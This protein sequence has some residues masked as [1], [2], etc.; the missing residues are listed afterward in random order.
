[1]PGSQRRG[2]VLREDFGGALLAA[3]KRGARRRAAARYSSRAAGRADSVIRDAGRSGAAGQPPDRPSQP[4]PGAWIALT[5]ATLAFAVGFAV[6]SLL[7]PL[8]P[9]F[10][11]QW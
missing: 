7:A 4:G 10:R 3:D 5:L 9:L 11:E 6:W 2:W 8:A 1:M